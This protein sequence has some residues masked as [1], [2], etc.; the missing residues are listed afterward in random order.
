MKSSVT[1]VKAR[2]C[3]QYPLPPILE[4]LLPPAVLAAVQRV[5]CRRV[6]EIRLRVGAQSAVTDECGCSLPLACNWSREQ[7]EALMRALCDGSRYSLAQCLDGGYV[8]PGGGVRVGVCGLGGKGEDAFCLQRVDAVCIRLPGHFPAVGEGIVTT[9]RACLPR[10]VLFFA[11]PGVGKTTLIRALAKHFS[12]GERPLR[13]VLVDSRRELDDGTFGSCGSLDILA[14]YPKESGMEIAVRTLGAQ[15]ILCDE[16]GAAEARAVLAVAS[17]GVPLIATAHA[18][19][20]RQL[21]V[22]PELRLLHR[23]GV[24]AAYVGL[25]RREMGAD[26]RYHVTRAEDAV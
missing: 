17:Y 22:R 16:L 10:G 26:Y 4:R 1:I 15:L 6:E 20:A 14:G 24:F 13:A 5:P 21:L 23:A 9:V 18:L 2:E 3:E 11:P 25:E 8:C 7:M 12:T 19:Q